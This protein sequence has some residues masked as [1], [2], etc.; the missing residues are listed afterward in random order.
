MKEDS[1]KINLY[2]LDFPKDTSVNYWKF[3]EQFTFTI[4][5]SLW[6]MK[7]FDIPAYL[8]VISKLTEPALNPPIQFV[9]KDI[10]QNQSISVHC[11]RETYYVYVN[12]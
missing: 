11:R 12:N 9:D 4:L 3:T 10:K 8:G 1:L 7:Y 2:N 6:T 5:Y